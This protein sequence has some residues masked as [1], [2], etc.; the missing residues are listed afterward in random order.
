MA[1]ENVVTNIV[2][3]ADFSDLISNVNKVNL[4]LSQLKQTLTNTD[5]AL[6]LNATK[7]QQG[8]ASTLRSTG[9]F[10]THFVNLTAD[11]DKFGKN[12]DQG[13]LKLRE[14][15]GVWQQHSR[16]SGGLI[17]DLARQQV[18]LQNA[19]IQPL[20]RNAEGLMQFNVN[21]PRGLDETK[22]KAA[23][24]KQEMQIFNKVI[25]DGGVQLIN[26]G[27]NTQWA[28]RQLT[29][30][31]TVPIAAFGKAAAD[32][33][34]EADEQLVRLTKVY[35][36]IAG[37]SAA[38]LATVRKEVAA[39]AKELAG[40]YGASYKETIALS[41]DIAATGKQGAELLNSVRETTRLSVL[42]E[43]DR[44]EA[45]KATLAIQTAFNQNTQ[46][47]A[48]SINFLNAVENQTS[49]TLNDLVEAI[50]KAGPVVKSLGGDIED[51]A[52]Y[53]T[54]MKEGGINASEGAN[55]IKSSLASLINPTKVA[56]EMFLG[57][58]IDLGQIVTSNAGN[59]TATILDLQ[60]A[61]DRLDPLSKTKA[62]EQLFGKFQFARL[63]ALFDNLGRQGSQTLQVLD[64]MN[65]SAGDLAS[66]AGRELAQI[67][68]SAS[69]RF[70]RALEQLKA[71]LAGV[72]EQ[73]LNVGTFLINVLDKIVN[74]ANKL[75][76]P[77]KTLMSLFAGFT[78]L[79][80]P[81]I[82]L[83]GVLANFLG[84]VVKGAAHLRAF[85]KGGEGWRLL[86]PEILAAQKAGNLVEQTF[87]NDAKAAMALGEA[88]SYVNDQL[89]Q[90]QTKAGS[91]TISSQPT[92]STI[93]GQTIIA[94]AREVVPSH[95][96]VSDRDTRSFSHPNPVSQ[97]TPEQKA[98]QTIFGIVPGAPLVN[99]KISN[100][101]QMYM[102][103]DL[104]KIEGVS[105]VR[106]VSTGIVA[107]EAAKWHAMTGALAMQ[108]KEEIALLKREV[109]ATGLITTSLSDSYQALLP[110]MSRLTSLAASESAQIVA[111]LQASKITVEQAR[112]RVIALNQQIE[113]MMGQAATG[114]ATAQG[115]TI[116][117]TQLPI[118]DQ[119]AFDPVTG[120]SNMKELTRPRNRNLIT[121][122]AEALRVKTFGAPYSTETT[123]PKRL[124][125]G[126]QVFTTEQGRFVP[127]QGNTD[128]V[129]AMLTPGEFV[130]TKE[131]TARDPE[132]LHLYNKGKAV[133]VP[134]QNKNKGG[135]I[136]GMQFFGRMMP[137]R[138]VK[139]LSTTRN[140]DVV[141]TV[142]G[143]K[144]RGAD[145]RGFISQIGD[146]PDPV[147]KQKYLDV[148]KNFTDKLTRSKK[149]PAL[150]SQTSRTLQSKN[151]SELN[152]RFVENGLD[153]L[154]YAEPRHG[155]H[156]TVSK[157]LGDGK[158]LVSNYIVDYTAATNLSAN[159][160]NLRPSDFLRRDLV[161]VAGVNKYRNQLR[162]AK[163]PL[164]QW[165]EAEEA[166][167]SAIRTRFENEAQR[168]GVSVDQL[169]TIGDRPELGA[170]F[171]FT[172]DVIPEIERVL[173]QY[174]PTALYERDYVALK[175]NKV[176]RIQ[177]KNMGG[178]IQNFG[179]N[180]VGRIVKSLSKSKLDKL[181]GKWKPQQQ[182]RQP[183]Y[184][185][186][187]GNQDPLHGPL[188]I[189]TTMVP[190]NM[191]N[192]PEWT[193]E[194]LYRDDRFARQAVLPQ[195]PIG[196]L[197]DRGKYILRQ[198]MAGNYG[199]LQTPGATEAVKTLS[200]KYTG[201]LYR[202]IFL[203]NNKSNPLPADILD[204][205]SQAKLTGD[206]T[207]LIG[208]EF[209]MRRSSWSQNR[210]IA[211]LF[212]P[213]HSAP[214]DQKAILLEAIVRNRNVVPSSEIF[215]DAKFSAPFGQKVAGH[216]SRSEQEA[217][218]GGKFRIV[219]AGNGK[220][221]LET[222]VDGARAGGGPVTGGRPYLVGENGPEIFVPKMSGGIIPGFSKGGVVPGVQY[223]AEENEQRIVQPRI[224]ASGYMKSMLLGQAAGFGLS[225]VGGRMFGGI[226]QMGGY[227]VGQ[228][229]TDMFLMS[230]AAGTAR[231]QTTLL[232]KAFQLFTKMPGPVKLIAVL[233][234]VGVAIKT[235]NDKINERRRIID[236]AFG[237]EEETVKKL[238]LNYKTLT[239]SIEK[240]KKEIELRNA[241]AAAFKY[242]TTKAPGQGI[243]ITVKEFDELKKQAKEQLPTEL[244][245][246]NVA[247]EQELAQ[248]ATQLKAMFVS[249]GMSVE[250]ANELIYAL[251]SISNKSAQALSVLGDKGFGTITDKASAAKST[252]ETFNNV[253]KNGNT[254]QLSKSLD[255]A[256]NAYNN[257][258]DSIENTKDK[259]G[260]LITSSESY[261]EILK[262]IKATSSGNVAIGI[263]G[264]NAI[265]KQNA[266]MNRLLNTTDTLASIMAK[267][268][269][270]TSGIALDFVNMGPAAAEALSIIIEKQREALKSG[271]YSQIVKDMAKVSK[272]NAEQIIQ[273]AELSA[274]AL[275]KEIELHNKKI[276]KIKEEADARKKALDE[277]N[278]DEDINLR[279]K[280]KQ[281]EYQD[282]LAAGDM[283]GAAQAQIAIQQLVGSQQVALAKRAIDLKAEE[284]I[285]KEQSLIDALN[286]R[287]DGLQNK[288]DSAKKTA[289]AANAKVENLSSL[290][291]E[292]LALTTSA[293][294]GELSPTEKD[295]LNLLISDLEKAG[296]KD[297]ARSLSGG[298]G[299]YVG[300]RFVPN[301]SGIEEIAKS[302]FG[303]AIYNEK[304]ELK[305]SDTEVLGLLK[306]ILSGTPT[307]TSGTK[308]S[309]DPATGG[310]QNRSTGVK[311]TREQARVMPVPVGG[312]AGS[313]QSFVHPTYGGGQSL[314]MLGPI[315]DVN[316]G[317][318][319][320]KKNGDVLKNNKLVGRWYNPGYDN[321]G[322]NFT[323]AQGGAVKHYAPGGD[324]MGPGTSTSDSIPAYLS[325][326]EYVIKASSVEKASRDLGPDFLDNL[327]AGRFA[328][329]GKVTKMGTADSMI[330]TAESML[331]YKEGR[332][333]DTI[334]GR[335]AQKA[336]DLQTRYIAWC[337]AFINWA[338]KKSG[339]D[340]SSM[341]WTPGGAQSF[342]KSGKWTTMS[343]VR[344]DL[345]FMDFPGDGVN[346]ISHVGL[347]RKVLSKNAVST[348]EGNTSGSGSQRS[349]GGVLA[350]VRQYN[351]KNAPIVGFGRPSYK[352]V[353]TIKYGYGTPEYYSADDAKSDYENDRYTVGRGDTL[354]AIAAKYGISVKQLMEM[355]PQL[356]DPKYMGGSRIFAGTKVNIKKF[357][358]G[359]KVTSSFD[360]S[361]NWIKG[362]LTVPRQKKP[363]VPYSRS[364]K[365]IGNPFGQYWGELSR[366]IGPR[367]PG[368]DI[369]G[370][371]EIPGLKFSGNVPQHSDYM[372]QMAEQPRKPFTSPGMGIDRDP[373]R[374][375]GSGASMGGIGS[376]AYGLGPLMFAGGGR[377][378][379]PLSD[380]GPS[381][382][383][384]GGLASKQSLL[385]KFMHKFLKTMDPFKFGK[386]SLGY[387]FLGGKEVANV[388]SGTGN[389]LDYLSAALLPLG[390]VGRGA[391][392]VPG[393]ISKLTPE[394]KSFGMADIDAKAVQDL[395]KLDPSSIKIPETGITFSPSSAKE[396]L[397]GWIQ[398]GSLSKAGAG[399]WELVQA[400]REA[401]LKAK[402]PKID[403]SDVGKFNE[404]YAK[405]FYDLLPDDVIK[406]FKGVRNTAGSA[407]RTGERDLSTYFS[408]NPHIA[409][410][411][412]AMI[413]S[414]KLGEELPMF[415]IDKKISQ[416]TNFLG[417]GAVRNSKAQ[418]SME[419]PQLLSGKDLLESLP[420]IYSLPA[421]VYGQMFG[422]APKTL[423]LVKNV[424]PFGFADGGMVSSAPHAMGM[425]SF[426]SSSPAKKQNWFQRYVS[427]LSGMPG[428][429]T[430]GTAAL[431]RK[432]AGQGRKGD[433]L[434]AAML[435]LNF[436]GAGLGSKIG[437]IS[438]AAS[439]A[440]SSPI[441]IKMGK[442]TKDINDVIKFPE[443][444]DYT[445]F[446]TLE[447]N[448]PA[449]L[450]IT[451]LVEHIKS[452]D[453]GYLKS[454]NEITPDEVR[455]EIFGS[456]FAGKAG[457]VA[458]V[459]KPYKTPYSFPHNLGIFSKSVDEISKG[460]ITEKII[461]EKLSKDPMFWSAFKPLENVSA[462]PTRTFA[463][464]GMT[465]ERSY[466]NAILDA[467]GYS[468]A[469]GGNLIINPIG[470]KAGAIDFGRIGDSK[471]SLDIFGDQQKSIDRLKN[472]YYQ[473]L[474][475][476]PESERDAYLEGLQRAQSTL[477]GIKDSDL[478]EMLSASGYSADSMPI[479]LYKQYIENVKTAIES[480]LSSKKIVGWDEDIPKISADADWYKKTNYGDTSDYAMGGPVRKYAGGGLIGKLAGILSKS[481]DLAYKPINLFNQ[482][483]NYFKA[484]KMVKKG[485]FHGSAD[486]GQN[487]DGPF[488]GVTDL[489]GDYARDPYYGMGFYGTS[490]K[491][492]ADLYAGG[493]NVPG[494]WGESY[495]S[496]NKIT[497][498][499]FGKYL[500][501]SKDLKRQNY[502]LWS[503]LSKEGFMGAGENLG[504][505]MN[506][507]GMT[508]SI[509][510][511]INA[512]QTGDISIDTAKWI[513]LNKPKGTILEE[514][515]LG[516]ARG[517]YVN[518]SSYSNMSVPAYAMGGAVGPRYNIP[519][520]TVS[521]GKNQIPGYN[522][523]GAVHHY[524]VG[525]FVVNAQP[526]Q[527][528]KMIATM[529]VDMLDQKNVMRAAMTG[530]GRRN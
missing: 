136:E 290:L 473:G 420:E 69:G 515:G 167:D 413:G 412:S 156:L 120:K 429:E 392:K 496:V 163:I 333:N 370:G 180:M 522:K 237:L 494:Q 149:D 452:G 195:F 161:K 71:D 529:V 287:I 353:D 446:K 43:V 31:L 162:A 72:G 328:N 335:F 330:K 485:M 221:Q 191:Q 270:S 158:V 402:Y 422:D 98:A 123:R 475:Y 145:A 36:G 449:S 11:V 40:Q 28:G 131:Q 527:D 205:I 492:E 59:L 95:P 520:N 138:I 430:F 219:D 323:F 414:A 358:Q 246:L 495:G 524:D 352:P 365:P 513:A 109:A 325:D 240:N 470:K 378:I 526:G 431:L 117:L 174:N 83:T 444:L 177:R 100:N 262:Q 84:Y 153:A 225:Q 47:L 375:A 269:L 97:M 260:K 160:N 76:G 213:G 126:G 208:R 187:L 241:A 501:F 217:I 165:D 428:A 80:G 63:S 510:P 292:L 206:Y 421:K 116:N 67:T 359:G 230:R 477:S 166:I 115:R 311:Y 490:S 481:K 21:I 487:S 354:S 65:A 264:V 186:T 258:A 184:Q 488:S 514:L 73:F 118:V 107:E 27:K 139:G 347:V 356:N 231:T 474:S 154:P 484:K 228:M 199:I 476:L 313:N 507:S 528:E 403:F 41:A 303:K 423:K 344:G 339:V 52:L 472:R 302:A 106:G 471:H 54:A 319:L 396:A 247:S 121:R 509:M 314:E 133:I 310:F 268:R 469:H 395:S 248:K 119:P 220:I 171:T 386:H 26:W 211:S 276:Q 5:K 77:V 486:L 306:K 460:S 17:R 295:R 157:K 530:V 164:S 242:T 259:N 135:M 389:K 327:N 215:P 226:G 130:V 181:T 521:L 169:P 503:L 441:K 243:D 46:E 343:P 147:L 320:Y 34:R 144:A 214:G 132:G 289:D 409:A 366:F 326:G 148:A 32:A 506:K 85:F 405:E 342:M 299:S 518:P 376:G 410:L 251:I 236:S 256:L 427:S 362:P 234:G 192:E 332:G 278:A 114:V 331:G 168:R 368:M 51:L 286:A 255:T 516:F 442:T 499:P 284:D 272:T 239:S 142:H 456:I 113:A 459:I 300:S 223:F 45:M 468:D 89:T 8:F 110:E 274:K 267:V 312:P 466:R 454:L 58:G 224:G 170:E 345:A 266:E 415:G 108:S 249:S 82:M 194:I 4:Q 75:P 238:N 440:A 146:I 96:L 483:M 232:T 307:P 70:R 390:G 19:I 74:F 416:L 257:L 22:N 68:E 129:P 12:L 498:I 190:K 62:I 505:L 349:G 433:S 44:Q 53:L 411:Y 381:R 407:W 16:T 364:G 491:A 418:G 38:E 207:P 275:R 463:A 425:S 305:T 200:R 196:N 404:Y 25:Q 64:L 322:S 294:D 137:N 182:F 173:T 384:N 178:I 291:T 37:S 500:D 393:A 508:G 337:G 519:T 151:V 336:Y 432:I 23:L 111:D 185:Y 367:S 159:Q 280:A 235:I 379:N 176:A 348:I 464:L 317:G 92:I 377:V 227:M 197:E 254:D 201:R 309:F 382:L 447:S 91:A 297:I 250:N 341:I 2:A 15:Y 340:L 56:K 189:G 124:N 391:A 150:H 172:K 152:S 57:L 229:A 363:G 125:M 233:L 373:M 112:A 122:I 277:E 90:L 360:D 88:L 3:S 209:I 394:M 279:I 406:L 60:K 443:L 61:L 271:P 7:I 50:P 400:Q 48:E 387:D 417:E 408:T 127:G 445:E 252:L 380:Y 30:G 435:P 104:P 296:Y 282:K 42:G 451:Q 81:I 502:G 523:G 222:V 212:A 480:R 128:T 273:N 33:F 263:E 140:R 141:E 493:Y 155:T 20:G 457:L 372:H 398:E 525:G 318:Y 101:P 438:K 369:W 374:M 218:F 298:G 465:S 504:P 193:R 66:V 301:P 210:D 49:T 346:R 351:M 1:S 453:T 315:K 183:G 357:A 461:V 244:K 437:G 350:K 35:G 436:M 401:L 198:Y 517:G 288:V 308:L 478:I 462:L 55:A 458:P 94:G 134:I 399:A 448:V 24:L 175:E 78:A 99:Q 216:N 321:P 203:K 281:L 87:Y 439:A 467:L 6:A 338:A 419:F 455:R 324:V 434:S 179:T 188:Q 383:A 245:M 388:F 479:K 10:S 397:K 14:Y 93:A 103:G 426:G 482:Y 293:T 265:V 511:R 261:Q 285:S 512:G 304:G 450:N 316:Q 253:I 202:G 204:L 18:A 497:K 385:S 105:S 29:V 79:A 86:T 371:T 489:S 283:S 361:G 9:Q 102:S 329:G 355:N 143:I 13:R 424:W 334:F 39:T